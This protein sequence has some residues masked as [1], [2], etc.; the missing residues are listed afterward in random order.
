MQIDC[1]SSLPKAPSYSQWTKSM[2]S[3][4]PLK[5]KRCQFLFG[6]LSQRQHFRNYLLVLVGMAQNCKELSIC[7]EEKKECSKVSALLRV[8]TLHHRSLTFQLLGAR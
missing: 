2:Q 3:I 4:I 6:L 5:L 8:E 1:K 7:T